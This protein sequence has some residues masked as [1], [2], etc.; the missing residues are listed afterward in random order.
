MYNVLCTIMCE[1]TH[2]SKD[3]AK[4]MFCY[5]LDRDRDVH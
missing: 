1:N 3:G 5:T 2:W 4:E